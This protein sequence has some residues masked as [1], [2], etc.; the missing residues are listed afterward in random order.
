[1]KKHL[2]SILTIVLAVAGSAFTLATPETKATQDCVWFIYDDGNG[3]APQTLTE[4]TDPMN[5]R[6]ATVGEEAS[7]CTDTEQLCAVCAP[8]SGNPNVPVLTSGTIIRADL[9]SYFSDPSQVF[10]TIKEKP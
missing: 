6:R 10:E 8:V 1:M 9:E 5:Y 7:L 4:A 2:L 3:G